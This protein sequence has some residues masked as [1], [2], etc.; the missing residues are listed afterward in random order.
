MFHAVI[1]DRRKYGPLGWNIRYDFTEGDLQISMTQMHQYLEDYAEVPYRVLR[2]LTSEINYGCRVTDDKDRRLI[3]MLLETFINEGVIEEGYKFSPSGVFAINDAVELKDY[4]A[5]ISQLPIAPAPEIFGLHENADI[6]CYQNETYA[7]FATI[8]S[9]QPRASGVTGASREE[10]IERKC[11][12]ISER[13][14]G[15]FDVAAVMEAYP[16][17]YSESMNT[18]IT[19]ECIRY[20]GLLG[21]MALSL[22]ETVKALKGLVVMS[23]ELEQVANAI[24]DNQVPAA[25]EKVAYPSLKPLSSWIVDLLERLSFIQKWIDEGP[26]PVYWISGVFFPQAFLTGTL[27]NYARKYSYAIDT[28]SFDFKVMD[29]VSVDEQKGP[30]D[31]CYIRGLFVEGA[32]WNPDKHALDES[33]PKELFT[34]MPVCWL[35]PA[36]DRVVPT[37]GIYDCPVYKTL[38]RKGELSTTGHSTNFVIFMEI[39]SDKDQQWW[40]CRGVALFCALGF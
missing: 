35:V 5:Y 29:H 21:V 37:S 26:P 14:P 9:L 34:D 18:V 36:K 19:Q 22:R 11:L 1:Q 25:W 13:I 40:A 38:A 23:G 39:P 12:E 30:E 24:F 17:S 32:R 7:M 33:L 6:T 3:N 27:Q 2:F 28:V 20:N 15:L 10:V 16:V 8:L 31:V 4:L